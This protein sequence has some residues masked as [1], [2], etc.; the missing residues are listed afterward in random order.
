MTGLGLLGSGWP[1]LLW[2][3]P[4]GDTGLPP[5]AFVG[6]WMVLFPCFGAASARVWR[7][8]E[9]ARARLALAT[10]GCALAVLV[11]FMPVACAAQE[12]WVTAA[13]DL[14]GL[15]TVG[16]A[17]WAYRTVSAAAARWLAPVIAWMP[18]TCAL[19]LAA[20]LR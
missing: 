4:A 16:L 20:A 19:S 17:G 5:L 7:S 2:P 12:P 9:G 6:V 1:L 3:P 13:M 15:V 10:G 14:L 11:A 8:G 18:V